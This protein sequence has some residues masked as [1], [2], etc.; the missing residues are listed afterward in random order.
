[1]DKTQIV[2]LITERTGVSNENVTKVID[3]LEDVAKNEMSAHFGGLTSNF[4]NMEGLSKLTGLLG[5]L[6]NNDSSNNQK[7]EGNNT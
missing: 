3:T 7:N 1:M 5:L 6:N 4:G 2:N